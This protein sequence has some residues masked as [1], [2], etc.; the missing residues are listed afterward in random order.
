MTLKDL[1]EW[2][3]KLPED[4]DEFLVVLRD[5]VLDENDPKILNFKDSPV[6]SALP[7]DQNKR[8]VFHGHEAQS[9]INEFRAKNVDSIKES[10]EKSK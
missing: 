7:D 1:R 4:K 2:V 10:Q 3:N 5:I 6:M 8:L 9:N